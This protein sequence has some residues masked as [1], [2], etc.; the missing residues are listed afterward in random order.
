LHFARLEIQSKGMKEFA[1]SLPTSEG[2]MDL[3]GFIPDGVP[4]RRLPSVIVLQEAFGV[5]PHIKRVCRRVASAGYAAFSPE[6]FHRAGAGLEF[7]Y[8]EFPKVKPILGA[9]TNG[10]I[11]EDLRAAHSHIVGRPDVDSARVASW[12]FCMGGWASVLAACE[13]PLAAAISFYGGGL[14][15]PRPGIGFTP[16]LDRLGSIRCPMLLVYGAKDTGIPQEDIDAVQSRLASLGKVHEVE[17][18]PNGGHGFF[19]EDRAAYDR[20]S[21]EASWTRAT[22]WLAAKLA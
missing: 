4:G 13:L 11:A 22:V 5:N 15:K 19:C 21:A 18:Y 16:L 7:G 9:L 20:D 10:Q 3:H 14:V 12:G 8:D 2:P 6:L 1:V 17:V